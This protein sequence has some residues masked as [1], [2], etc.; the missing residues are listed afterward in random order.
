[1]NLLRDAFTLV[2]D[3]HP[4]G[5]LEPDGNGCLVLHVVCTYASH[6]GEFGLFMIQ[7]LVDACPDAV[8]L[9]NV[10][11]VYPLNILVESFSLRNVRIAT[12]LTGNGLETVKEVALCLLKVNPSL[13]R[14]VLP[15]AEYGEHSALSLFCHLY[16]E[17]YPRFSCK[18][19]WH[20]GELLLRT[21][22]CGSVEEST[23]ADVALNSK[24]RV[25]HAIASLPLSFRTFEFLKRAIELYPEQLSERSSS[26]N[27]PL[28]LAVMA[29][30][31][32][33][34]ADANFNIIELLLNANP[35]AI[36]MPNRKGVLPLSVAI[37][38]KKDWKRCV[39]LL[40]QGAP[41]SLVARERRSRLYPF[42]I[43]A[44]V[45]D[46]SLSFELLRF[47]PDL[48]RFGIPVDA[49]EIDDVDVSNSSSASINQLSH[50]CECSS[51]NSIA[52]VGQSR[53]E[54]EKIL[55]IKREQ[56]L[57]RLQRKIDV[58]QS[59]SEV[60]K[61]D[62]VTEDRDFVHQ[63]QVTS[64]SSSSSIVV[65]GDDNQQCIVS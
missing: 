29:P 11:G 31:N 59:A 38:S 13:V 42:M 51:D 33:N 3:A 15:H 30:M 48:I 54:E 25:V 6:L 2:L 4:Q 65:D 36:L 12:N 17:H 62:A 21:F 39:R 20:V 63:Q 53:C 32:E 61:R 24:W 28:M 44:S 22:L 1:L 43:A 5:P 7:S 58:A 57:Q 19:L 60:E 37:V 18:Y 56:I 55:T 50:G 47:C 45:A 10:N 16:S 52:A 34:Y 41:E 14:L 35:S 27:T 40:V 9:K 23:S 46:V 8:S 26:G 64:E 49:A